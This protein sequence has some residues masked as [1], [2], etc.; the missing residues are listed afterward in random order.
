[1]P[2]LSGYTIEEP[3]ICIHM[4]VICYNNFPILTSIIRVL[5][6]LFPITKMSVKFR[7]K[8]IQLLTQENLDSA[9]EERDVYSVQIFHRRF[10]GTDKF[11]S[12]HNRRVYLPRHHAGINCDR[13]DEV[14]FTLVIN[15]F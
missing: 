14:E 9:T 13:S 15:V 11:S 3:F 7:I 12:V 4:D 2:L 10:I 8:R 6:D 5:G 1:M